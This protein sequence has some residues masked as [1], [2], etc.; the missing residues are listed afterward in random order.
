MQV[1]KIKPE[2]HGEGKQVGDL[3]EQAENGQPAQV[4]DQRQEEQRRQDHHQPLV[5]GHGRPEVG[6]QV[7]RNENEVG[8]A[9]SNLGNQQASV[10]DISANMTEG[11]KSDITISDSIFS[12]VKS[13]LW[14]ARPAATEKENKSSKHLFL[15]V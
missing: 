14:R 12:S 7:L 11:C 10:N 2:H 1:V 8:T 4:R 5:L 15:A 9:K 6:G 3:S 13:S